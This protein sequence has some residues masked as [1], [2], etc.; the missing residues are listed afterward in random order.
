MKKYT[1]K[2]LKALPT[3]CIGQT[4]DLKIEVANKRVWLSRLTTELK[5]VPYNNQV[6]VEKYIDGEW[7]IEE[8]YEAK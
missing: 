3:L 7:I 5:G 6:T 8:Q 4:D 2:E 1:L